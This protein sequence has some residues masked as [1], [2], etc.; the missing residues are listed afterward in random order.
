VARASETTRQAGARVKS[1][2]K[3]F[4]P[5]FFRRAPRRSFYF[6]LDV[7]NPTLTSDEDIPRTEDKLMFW[8]HRIAELAGERERLHASDPG[9]EMKSAEIDKKVSDA[10][11]RMQ[12]L[13]AVLKS[14]NQN[15]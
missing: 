2:D 15:R 13:F 9:Y 10:N 11:A 8:S 4:P 14:L 12:E 6:S 7:E 3:A 5:A 1:A